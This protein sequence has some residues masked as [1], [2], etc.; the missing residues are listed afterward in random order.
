[1]ASVSTTTGSNPGSTR[2]FLLDHENLIIVI[3]LAVLLWWGWGKFAQ[4]R[5]DHDAA[6]LKQV[7]AVAT[8]QATQDTALAQQAL[9]DKAQLQALADKV[10]AQNAQ[11]VATN[12]ALASALNQRRH[13]DA[14]LPPPVLVQRWTQITPGMPPNGVM[15]TTD[16]M[17][18][19]PTIVVTQAGAVATVQQLEQVPVL[20]Q[21]LN[22]ETAQK[23]NDD[24]LLASSHQDIATLSEQVTGLNQ[25]VVDNQNVCT[26]QIKLV[27]AQAAKS[28]RR[29]FVIGYVAGFLSRQFIGKGL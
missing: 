5:I 13:T 25:Q 7:M 16:N 15:V 12:A 24:Q 27:K 18:R 23:D 22:D 11:L 4:M 10:A 2:S 20:Q 1:M 6:Q 17:T 26:D 28:K 9:V 14:A 3:I 19:I 29:W 21:E 8:Q